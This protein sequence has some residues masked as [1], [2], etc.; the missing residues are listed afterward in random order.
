MY[1]V[2]IPGRRPQ[3]T[4]SIIVARAMA[5]MLKGIVKDSKGAVVYAKEK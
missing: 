2:L 4:N 5:N 1:L 3:T